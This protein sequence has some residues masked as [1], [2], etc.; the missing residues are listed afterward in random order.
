MKSPG[1]CPLKWSCFHYDA[2]KAFIV[3]T[4][5]EKEFDLFGFGPD[6][7][8][9]PAASGAAASSN[10]FVFEAPASPTAPQAS[11]SPTGGVQAGGSPSGGVTV[12]EGDQTA[13]LVGLL[14]QSLQQN[15]R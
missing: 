11:S 5:P 3:D 8:P 13:L 10:S 4:T 12:G 7:G 6:P 1:K 9:A 15:Q 2:E 14:R